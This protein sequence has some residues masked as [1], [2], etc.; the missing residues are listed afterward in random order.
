M[1]KLN[2]HYIAHIVSFLVILLLI[3]INFGQNK[4]VISYPVKDLRVQVDSLNNLLL[5][6]Q[7]SINYLQTKIVQNIKQQNEKTD[8]KIKSYPNLTNDEFD[9]LW[10]GYHSEKDSLPTGSW[11]ILEQRAGSLGIATARVEKTLQK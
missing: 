2:G 4:T 3:I 8:K 10:S 9:Q 11:N 6:Q 1:K 5:D 7:D